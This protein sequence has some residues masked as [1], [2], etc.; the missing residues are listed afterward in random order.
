MMRGRAEAARRAHNPEVGGSNP[1]PATS[2]HPQPLSH[3]WERN[4]FISIGARFEPDIVGSGGGFNE[5]YQFDLLETRWIQANWKIVK[6]R[7][8]TFNPPLR[9][10]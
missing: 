5:P 1:P 3:T 7:I 6:T 4:Y 8:Y 9:F 2:P 10:P